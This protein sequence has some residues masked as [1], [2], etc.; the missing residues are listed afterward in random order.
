MSDEVCKRLTTLCYIKQNGKYL[1][2]HRV[3]KE[4][5]INKDKW[6]GIGGHFKPGESPEECVL[7]E[8]YEETG[9]KLTSFRLR[10]VISFV[11]DNGEYEYMFLFTADAFEGVLNDPD[12]CDEGRLEWVDADKV[13]DLNIWEG[14]KVFFR[15]LEEREEFF[16]LKLEYVGD[17][18]V[19]AVL[20]G[21]GL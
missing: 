3:K 19:R 1:M 15:L 7:R 17:R 8:A 14:D 16:S 20:D 2:M 12:Y 5:D 11:P 21:E 9:L 18:L 4:N 13:Y 6:L 10:G